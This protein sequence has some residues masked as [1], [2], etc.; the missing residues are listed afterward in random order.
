MTRKKKSDE[1]EQALEAAEGAGDLLALMTWFIFGAVLF[2]P[3]MR[4]INWQ[5]VVYAVASLTV[6]R[7]LPVAISVLGTGSRVETKLFLGWFGPR[8]LASIVFAV[9]VIKAKLPGGDTLVATTACTILLSILL[10]GLTAN[11]LAAAYG[12][13]A[14]NNQAD[15]ADHA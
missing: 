13:R 11:P 6:V 5:M 3:P 9:M 12:R 10:H 7:M 14:R 1:R 15:Q 4:T 8:G 2:V